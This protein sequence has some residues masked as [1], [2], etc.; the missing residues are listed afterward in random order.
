MIRPYKVAQIMG[1]SNVARQWRTP[2]ELTPG[3]YAWWSVRGEKISVLATTAYNAGP[4][5]V[6][7][8]NGVPPY[9]ET[10]QY[11][12]NVVAHYYQ[13]KRA[14]KQTQVAD[15]APGPAAARGA[16]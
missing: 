8:Y 4:D 16:P 2:G 3:P 6:R 7:K 1:A 13:L 15:S 14:A 10:R 5:A 12:K 11:V 9:E